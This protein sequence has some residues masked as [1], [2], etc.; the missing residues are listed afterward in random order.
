VVS[1]RFDLS[2]LDWG[3][4]GLQPDYFRLE[5]VEEW[6]DYRLHLQ[7][8]QLEPGRIGSTGTVGMA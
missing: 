6:E 5:M 1:S 3:W 4:V 8:H 2:R 7:H